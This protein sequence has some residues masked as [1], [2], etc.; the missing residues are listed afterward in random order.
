M[1]WAGFKGRWICCRLC[2]LICIVLVPINL[3]D[4]DMFKFQCSQSSMQNTCPKKLSF[5]SALWY[6]IM[7]KGNANNAFYHRCND[8]C[9][10]LETVNCII[11]DENA[12][13]KVGTS[14]KM[15]SANIFSI[16][17][18]KYEREQGSIQR[19]QRQLKIRQMGANHYLLFVSFI[20]YLSTSISNC[21]RYFSLKYTHFP[22]LSHFLHKASKIRLNILKRQIL[23]YSLGSHF[24]ETDF[25]QKK[26]TV[27]G[28]TT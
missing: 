16:L 27:K 15:K 23:H 4:L 20:S 26:Q 3:W 2:L 11:W 1:I 7:Q 19:K 10:S 13:S 9:A 18:T 14:K 12:W 17:C 8:V 22:F 6:K 28:L 24:Q 25:E 5:C 21:E